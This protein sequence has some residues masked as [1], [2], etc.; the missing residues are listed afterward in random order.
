MALTPDERAQLENLW[1]SHTQRVNEIRNDTNLTA[2]GKAATLD[3][4][5]DR[6]QGAIDDA[7]ARSD[8][9]AQADGSRAYRQAFGVPAGADGSMIMAHRDARDRLAEAGPGEAGR[10]LNTA[11]TT[12]DETLARAAGERAFNMAGPSDLGSHWGNLLTR[13]AASTPE[14]QRAVGD[15]AAARLAGSPA[16]DAGEGMMRQLRKPAEIA[17]GNPRARAA[18][19]RAAATQAG[20]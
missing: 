17:Y 9:Q 11:L 5:Y 1:R 13:F 10:A 4:N 14:R 20:G 3:D 6:H 8:Q 15:L 19:A 7:F 12:G 2:Q 16:T 18:A